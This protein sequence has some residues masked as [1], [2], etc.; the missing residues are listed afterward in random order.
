M[1]PPRTGKPWKNRDGYLYVVVGKEDPRANA[2]GAIFQHR[3]VMSGRLGRPL[4]GDES[5]HHINGQRD[6]NRLENLELWTRSQPPG[7]RVND[8][9]AW[10]LELLAL[11]EPARLAA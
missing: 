5:V 7:Q 9:V 1:G 6:D 11:Y 10:A 8:K 3:L 4:R 2:A